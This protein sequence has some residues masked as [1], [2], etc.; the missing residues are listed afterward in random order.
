MINSL[1]VDAIQAD[2]E[3]GQTL[4]KIKLDENEN[5]RPFKETEVLQGYNASYVKS[6]LGETN[7]KHAYGLIIAS[8]AP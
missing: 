6:S 8:A 3:L 7:D 1:T 5:L 2:S 4:R